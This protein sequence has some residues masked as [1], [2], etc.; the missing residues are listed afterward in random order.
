MTDDALN[1]WQA[2]ADQLA[3]VL[4]TLP[5]FDT[6]DPGYADWLVKAHD[7]VDAWRAARSDGSDGER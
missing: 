1:Q 5:P 7:A 4:L 3:E 6:G 2:L